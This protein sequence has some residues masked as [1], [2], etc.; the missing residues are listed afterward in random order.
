MNRRIQ[1]LIGIIV[2]SAYVA[3]A[4]DGS[5]GGR[6][7]QP[8]G[9]VAAAAVDRENGNRYNGTIDPQTGQFKIAG[10]PLGR[11]YDC[12]IDYAGARLEGVSMIVPPSDYVEE[13]P[14]SEEDIEIIT[15]KVRRLNT[16]ENEVEIMTIEG[17]IQHAA[18]LLNKLRTGGFYDSASG[19]VI[20]RA[21]LWNFERP[22]ETWVR[23][24]ETMFILYYR[25][26]IQASQ[27]AAK[28]LTFDSALGG[29]EI[30]AALPPVDLGDIAP[31]VAGK[32]VHY[33]GKPATGEAE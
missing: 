4:A 29:I 17:N 22:E 13:Q 10:L 19:E 33:R 26:R 5:I 8:D 30:K 25:E 1:F 20:W 7:T 3:Q 28:S 32:G 9:A 6:L 18:V 2:A 24:Q 31:P 11:S 27:Y 21:E 14:L 12:I 23:V 16:F 15:R